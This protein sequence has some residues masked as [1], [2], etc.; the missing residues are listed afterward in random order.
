MSSI[1]PPEAFA[2]AVAKVTAVLDGQPVDAKTKALLNRAAPADGP[3][4]E[5]IERLCRRGLD[6]GW[7]CTRGRPPLRYG[8]VVR[9]GEATHGFSVDVVLMEDVE[10]PSHAHPNGEIDMVMPLDDGAR[11]DGTRRGWHVYEPG[12]RHSPTVTGGRALILYL[13]PHGAIEFIS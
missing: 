1:V 5:D 4:F 9:P 13:L 12:S 2:Q 11:F 8:R 6:E 3:V 7:L 10:G